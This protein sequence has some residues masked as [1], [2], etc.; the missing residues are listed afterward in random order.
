LA[1]ANAEVWLGFAR[2]YREAAG[3]PPHRPEQ[4][5]NALVFL[6]SDAASGINGVN[7]LVDS[8]HVMSTIS[9]SW[10]AD[11]PFLDLLLGRA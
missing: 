6:N 5:A 4:I 1:R 11:R 7:L 9:G 2:E 8:G 3:I 10:E